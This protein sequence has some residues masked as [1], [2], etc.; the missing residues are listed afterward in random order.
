MCVKNGSNT[1]ET[2]L[3]SIKKNNPFEII[4]VDGNSKDGSIEIGKNYT[5]IILS[6]EGKGLAYA[7]Q[8]GADT[9]KGEYIAYV[10]SDIEIPENNL[11]MKMLNEML[12]N[13]FAGIHA[14]MIDPRENKP[15]WAEGEDFHWRNVINKPGERKIIGTATAVIKRDIIMKYRFDPFFSGATEDW[16]FYYRA[17]RD[18]CKFGISKYQAFHLHRTSK[19]NFIKQRIW[20]GKGNAKA[21]IKDN[22]LLFLIGPFVICFNGVRL[23]LK[24]RKLKFIYFYFVWMMMLMYGTYKGLIEHL[25]LRKNVA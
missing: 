13:D 14:Q 6:D 25:F 2:A 10:D 7:R 5:D 23:C 4:I 9:A 18:G 17:G 11:L 12:E 22:Y 8:L 19:K 16:D 24:K 21:I 3:K 20:Y 15:Y 1:M